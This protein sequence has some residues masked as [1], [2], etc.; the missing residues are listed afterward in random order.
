MLYLLF[1][2]ISCFI[3]AENLDRELRFNVPQ[4]IDISGSVVIGDLNG[5]KDC[6]SIVRGRKKEIKE[7]LDEHDEEVSDAHEAI[8]SKI[9]VI[10]ETIGNSFEQTSSQLDLLNISL[11]EKLE[12]LNDTVL[13]NSDVLVSVI[14]ETQS[15]LCSKIENIDENLISDTD[16]IVSELDELESVVCSKIENIEFED[17][18]CDFLITQADMDPSFTI[19]TPGKYCVAENLSFVGGQNAAIIIASDNVTLDLCGHTISG[20]SGLSGIFA[21]GVSKITVKNGIINNILE[22]IMFLDVTLFRIEDICIDTSGGDTGQGVALAGAQGIRNGV[23]SNVF[24]RGDTRFGFFVRSG[25]DIMFSNCMSVNSLTGFDVVN[26]SRILFCSC[27]ANNN[28][29]GFSMSSSEI[30]YKCCLANNNNNIGFNIEGN[31]NILRNCFAMENEEDGFTIR[32]SNNE[33]TGCAAINNTGTGIRETGSNTH[34]Y[35]NRSND[36]GTD[37]SGVSPVVASGAVSS[38]TGYW[39]NISS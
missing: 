28:D 31:R 12:N 11:C 27:I 2:A 4:K 32:M 29:T 5:I 38:S 10:D 16:G 35:N 13:S 17:P 14:D 18:C 25:N 7:L 9:E 39:A 8:C 37:Y 34:L 1:L 20:M 36:N 6:L 30:I 23:V 15:L 26:S 22:G 24:V 3:C 19:S 33:V 21:Q